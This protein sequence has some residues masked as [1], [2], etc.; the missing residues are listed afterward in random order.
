M[1]AH[2]T[3]T[4]RPYCY[5][6]G[7][8]WNEELNKGALVVSLAAPGDGTHSNLGYTPDKENDKAG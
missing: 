1:M 8:M 5:Y 6:E 2:R 7:D 3:K 4:N